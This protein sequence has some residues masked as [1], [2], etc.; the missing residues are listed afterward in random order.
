MASS[1]VA[2]LFRKASVLERHMKDLPEGLD[3]KRVNRYLAVFR[4]D[5]ERKFPDDVRGQVE[6][7]LAKKRKFLDG[8]V[9]PRYNNRECFYA[10]GLLVQSLRVECAACGVMSTDG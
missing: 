1:S 2:G 5:L 10:L 3:Q 7:C 4:A 6:A 8:T 9:N